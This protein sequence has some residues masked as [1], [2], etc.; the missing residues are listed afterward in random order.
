MADRIQLRRDTAANWAAIN[1]ILADGEIGLERDTAQFKIGT[2]TTPYS[3]LPYGGM[4]GPAY[5]WGTIPGT[6]ADQADLQAALDAKARKQDP[7]LSGIVTLQGALREEIATLN[8]TFEALN[9]LDGT[10]QHHTLSANTTYID[11]L[12]SGQSMTLML[13]ANSTVT[14]TWP[15]ITWLTNA[16]QPP[17]LTIPGITAIVLWKLDA[18]LYGALVGDGG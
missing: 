2:G 3:A 9:P 10:L 15:V 1:P 14:V 5:T 4:Q 7:V 6:L 16:G 8:G 11:A 18:T 13:T 12:L 17:V